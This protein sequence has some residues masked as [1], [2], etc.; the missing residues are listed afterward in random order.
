MVVKG[1]RTY[2]HELLIEGVKKVSF[3]YT[4]LFDKV[5]KNILNY[6]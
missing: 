5:K 1:L 3:E 4:A 6:N 2:K